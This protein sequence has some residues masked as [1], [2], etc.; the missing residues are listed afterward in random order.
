MSALI[1]WKLL[2]PEWDTSF[3]SSNSCEINWITVR[4]V[5]I[6]TNLFQSSQGRRTRLTPR[7]RWQNELGSY[8]AAMHPSDTDGQS[9]QSKMSRT[10]SSRMPEDFTKGTE[11]LF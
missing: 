5:Q 4:T 7:S 10:C 6:S 2:K 3:R 8:I 11:I 1:I 9:G